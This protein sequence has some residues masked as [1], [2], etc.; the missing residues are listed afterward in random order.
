MFNEFLNK[1]QELYQSKSAFAIALVVNRQIPSSGKPGDK[2]IIQQDGKIIGWIGGG[3]TRGIVL[4]EAADALKDG[5]PRLVKI[6][7]EKSNAE[8]QKGVIEYRMTCQ[9]GGS[10]DIYIEPILPRPQILIMGKSH[11]AM[12]LSRLAKA[13]DY[14]IQ[15]F[16]SGVDPVAFPDADQVVETG[17]KPNFVQANTCIVVCTQGENDEQALK[18]ALESGAEYVS[19]V[20]SRRKAN[21][22]YNVI[23]RQGVSMDQLKRI[24]SPA[25]LD[26]NAKLPEEVAVSILAEIVAFIRKDPPVSAEPARDESPMSAEQFYINPVC[27]IPVEKKTAKHQL[28]YA[29]TEV[30]FCCDGCKIKFEEAPSKYLPVHAD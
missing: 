6:S 1:Q 24:K 16:A 11:V 30:Y 10:V 13:M 22:V 12:A 9:S 23:R 25:G 5:K 3:C 20:A 18:Q 19:F 29:G 14:P 15:V 27:G 7:P 17:L 4:K 28:N 8:Q 26:I 2:A 21:A